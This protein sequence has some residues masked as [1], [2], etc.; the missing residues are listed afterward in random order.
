MHELNITALAGGVG[1]ARFLRGLV[2]IIDPT[3]L[4]VIV[5]TGDDEE[6]FGLYVSPYLDT[7]TY[8]LAGAVD[9]EKGWGLPEETF[10][11]LA[12]LK[13]YYSSGMWFGLGDTDFATHLFR[14]DFLRQ[15]KTLSETTM[16]I[17][18]AWGVQSTIL[19]M[20]DEK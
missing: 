11:C 4:N 10:Q 17:A 16:A 3:R 18:H 13:R 19:P 6:F 20:S 1:A 5:N 14:T 7:I 8:T 2:R 12:A 9:H 15:G